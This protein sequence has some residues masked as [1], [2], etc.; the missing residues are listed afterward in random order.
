MNELDDTEHCHRDNHPTGP[1][2]RPNGLG[3]PLP[4]M[5]AAI[6]KRRAPADRQQDWQCQCAACKDARCGEGVTEKARVGRRGAMRI[7]RAQFGKAVNEV[8][9]QRAYSSDYESDG[10]LPFEVECWF[11]HVL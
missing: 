2:S 8:S 4:I 1:P 6:C 9:G 11:A 7:E 3:D 10:Y 5:S